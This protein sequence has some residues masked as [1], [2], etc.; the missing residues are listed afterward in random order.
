MPI[1]PNEILAVIRGTGKKK[2]NSGID[3][4]LARL[5]QKAGIP[6]TEE[7]L[8]EKERSVLREGIRNSMEIYGLTKQADNLTNALQTQKKG[9]LASSI[10]LELD[11]MRDENQPKSD[12]IGTEQHTPID[13]TSEITIDPATNKPRK[14]IFKKEDSIKQGEK[15][16]YSLGA[17]DYL[18]AVTFMPD[19]VLDFFGVGKPN[20]PS[21]LEKVNNLVPDEYKPK[22]V[23]EG[24]TGN[25]DALIQQIVEETEKNN[26]DDNN[27][28]DLLMKGGGRALIQ[29]T[30]AS[31]GINLPKNEQLRQDIQRQKRDAS[32]SFIEQLPLINP[33]VT[34]ELAGYLLQLGVIAKGI[35]EPVVNR[36]IGSKGQYVDD[37]LKGAE[38]LFAKVN[39][40]IVG[41][42]QSI[43]AD[44][45]K[46]LLKEGNAPSKIYTTMLDGFTKR[47]GPKAGEMFE[48]YAPRM[49]RENITFGA[50][51]AIKGLSEVTQGKLEFE[52]Y[53]KQLLGTS[54]LATAFALN[55]FNE[56]L[57]KTV[58]KLDDMVSKTKLSGLTQMSKL[59]VGQEKETA[60]RMLESYLKQNG[61]TMAD[62]E[63]IAN[64]KTLKILPESVPQYVSRFAKGLVYDATV[65]GLASQVPGVLSGDGIDGKQLL[66]DAVMNTAFRIMHLS[67]RGEKEATY[68]KPGFE[69]KPVPGQLPESKNGEVPIF[70]PTKGPTAP[71]F[72][73]AKIKPEEIQKIRDLHTLV[74]EH[75]K[76]V[77][78]KIKQEIETKI[79]MEEVPI[80]KTIDG[81]IEIPGLEEAFDMLDLP[82]AKPA[83]D[84]QINGENSKLKDAPINYDNLIDNRV[85]IPYDNG[86]NKKGSAD[87]IDYGGRKIVVL[88]INGK[89]V[90]FYLSSGL[91]GK[92]NVSSGKWYPILGI[93]T[94][95]GW[96]NKGTETGI[97]FFFSVVSTSSTI[98]GNVSSPFSL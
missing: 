29:D 32:K 58:Q 34:G 6:I 7:D 60:E 71:V 93:D 97:F 56:P 73:A 15:T 89:N 17:K 82:V 27:Y 49:I 62:A 14:N 11:K 24:F 26:I 53:A 30:F 95:T 75:N 72:D 48:K 18:K 35:S 64:G 5:R 55:P 4:E 90:P 45:I 52:D 39:P 31:L 59:G 65:P 44:G 74:E 47:F 22:A 81:D 40:G 76:A 96:F 20:E 84:K 79:E 41:R 86:G 50:P 88:D 23:K 37:T 61:L 9:R 92:K 10:G 21:T 66:H 91:S 67:G 98:G 8:S 16:D 2:S 80:E 38:N 36:I 33:E 46:T 54:A 94:E 85:K 87:V 68:Q 12:V 25:A 51:T 19:G 13:T 43:G 42:T 69:P 3:P 70:D 78:P 1:D 57:K 83:P 77:D 28:F 63:A